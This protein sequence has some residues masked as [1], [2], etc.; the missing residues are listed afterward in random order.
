[1]LGI[2]GSEMK[3]VKDMTAYALWEK[4]VVKD[5]DNDKDEAD[6]ETCKVNFHAGKGTIKVKEL[7][8]IKDGS[9]YLPLPERK[10]Y[11][12]T[13]WYL[14][15]D[16]TQ[17]AGAYRDTYRI[18]KDTDFYAKW[19]RA[20]DNGDSGDSGNS[21]N[22]SGNGNEDGTQDGDNNSGETL[23]TYTI[24]Y[25]AN[26]GKTKNASVKVVK[27][28]SVKLPGA[29]RE[30]YTFK[31]WYTDRQVFIGTEGETYK[32]GRS[33]SLYARWEKEEKDGQD[34]QDSNRVGNTNGKG[35]KNTLDKNKNTSGTVSGN[36][37]GSPSDKN[38]DTDTATKTEGGNGNDGKGSEPVIQ[39]GYAS[40]F[41]FLAALGLCGA[42][43]IGA[44]VLE[45]KKSRKGCL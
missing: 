19:E 36:T 14:D 10:G 6:P 35:D 24:K 16:L 25:D 17:F 13:G 27:G 34:N 42:A 45:A 7:T 8:I 41:A 32:P 33:I 29:E 3:A 12:F 31:G 39:T 43:L 38:K 11:D 44:S 15:D 28:G 23:N 18:T 26:G 5:N 20:K 30:G 2:P 9:L 1:M 22:G 40:P 21:G 4:E 37:A